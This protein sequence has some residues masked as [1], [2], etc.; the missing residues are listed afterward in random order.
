VF[1]GLYST[2]RIGIAFSVVSAWIPVT[3]GRNPLPR[4]DSRTASI[5]LYGCQNWAL[6]RADK[7]R[8]EKAKKKYLRKVAG[9]VLSR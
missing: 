6:S 7:R 3:L 4:T 2:S 1:L 9:H 5:L 8:I